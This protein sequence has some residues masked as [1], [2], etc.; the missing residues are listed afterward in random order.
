MGSSLKIRVGLLES[1]AEYIDE[2]C[3]IKITKKISGIK[4]N[5]RQLRKDNNI[6]SRCVELGD[7]YVAK[8]E[9][10]T[11]KKAIKYVSTEAI[12]YSILGLTKKLTTGKVA[13]FS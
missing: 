3:Y 8:L 1:E 2:Y 6:K 13:I 4:V 5:V 7:F 9:E 10:P 11:I 12:K